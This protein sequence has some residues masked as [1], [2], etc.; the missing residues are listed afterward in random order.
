MLRDSI[1]PLEIQI[2]R[3]GLFI[4]LLGCIGLFIVLRYFILPG[5]VHLEVREAQQ[6]IQRINNS[7]E[8]ELQTLDIRTLD[9]SAR[10]DTVTFIKTGD[11]EYIQSNLVGGIVEKLDLHYLQFLTLSGESRWQGSTPT[12]SDEDVVAINA[13]NKNLLQVQSPEEEADRQVSPKNGV[14]AVAD[15]LFILSMRPIVSST[16]KGP[17]HGMLLMGKFIDTDKLQEQTGISFTFEYLAGNS[18]DPIT[19][20]I[21]QQIHKG[22]PYPI[23]KMDKENFVMSATVKDITGREAFL[24]RTNYPKEISRAGILLVKKAM[25]FSIV[26]ALLL[27]A[28]LLLLLNRVLLTP[29]HRLS[30][31]VHSVLK[32]EDYS[33]QI[34]MDRKDDIGILAGTFDR[35]LMQMGSQTAAL[36]EANKLLEKS[37]LTDALTGI[38]NRRKLDLSLEQ[39]WQNHLRQQEPLTMIMC[40]LDHFKLYNDTYGYDKGDTCLKI[41]AQV[42]SDS[43]NRP[44]DLVSR[45]GGEEFALLL[46]NTDTAGAAL[47]AANISKALFDQQIEHNSSPT[48]PVVTISLG[49]TTMIPED[50]QD[51]DALLKSADQALCRAKAQGRNQVCTSS[52]ICI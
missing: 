33:R 6:S 25:F 42:L 49:V 51:Q 2:I 47:I 8:G 19:A 5:F 32:T 23:K 39:A 7:I 37:S 26:G 46:P 24:L 22:T 43:L 27:F 17:S 18:L 21:L 4:I 38:A 16:G 36:L 31:H 14:I 40:D 41:V 28:I 9:W 29:I 11:E 44:S 45:Y 15:K 12:V 52:H 34:G 3:I 50:R 35:L 48:S 20:D 1:R 30:V 13:L 10:D